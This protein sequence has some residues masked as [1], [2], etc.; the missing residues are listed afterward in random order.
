VPSFS[1]SIDVSQAPADVFPWLL[2]EDKVPKWTGDLDTYEQLGP[3]A[4]GSQVKQVLSFGGNRITVDLEVTVY[5]PPRAAETRFSSNG[6]DVTSVYALEPAGAG[7][8]L[9]QTLDAKAT[10]FTARMLIPVVQG[11]L[12]QKLTQDLERLK[13]LLDGV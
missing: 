1:H 9:T 2:D 13:V 10:S 7:S 3:L 5:D 8:R 12:E 11:R 4:Q 6:V